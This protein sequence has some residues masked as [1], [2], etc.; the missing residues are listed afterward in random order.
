MG[1]TLK[2]QIAL[3]LGSELLERLKEV[4]KHE[5]RS[6]DNSVERPVMNCMYNQPNE[7]FREAIVEVRAGR[8]VE[9][10]RLSGLESFINRSLIWN[11]AHLLWYKSEGG[12]KEA[13]SVT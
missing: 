9:T 3:R 13:G 4:A 11:K 6:L 10:L 7:E 8:S 2:K 1:T 5:Y 12:I